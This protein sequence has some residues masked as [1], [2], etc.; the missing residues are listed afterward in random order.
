[1]TDQAQRI[2]VLF[3]ATFAAHRTVMRGGGTEPLYRPGRGD[4]PALVVYTRDYP[5]S[6]L[7]EAAHWCLAGA[8]RRQLT[9][10]GYWYVP[11]PR[12]SAQRRAFFAAECE[13][14]ALEAVFA[15]AAGVAF[16]VSADDFTAPHAELEEFARRVARRTAELATARLP[17][18]AQQFRAALQ[19]HLGNG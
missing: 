15:N 11:G 10:Y 8:R 17:P 18:R 6:A 5:A 12:D 13:V 14:Q 3:D 7:H 16:V 2:A 9:D 19:R 1:M 4:A